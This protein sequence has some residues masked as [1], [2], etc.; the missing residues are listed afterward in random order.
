LYSVG[1]FPGET[2]PWK[3]TSGISSGRPSHASIGRSIGT[4]PIVAGHVIPP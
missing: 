3:Y 2:S 1:L 4:A